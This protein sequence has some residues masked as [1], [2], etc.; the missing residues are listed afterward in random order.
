MVL[1]GHTLF[2]AI[3]VQTWTENDWTDCITAV[4]LGITILVVAIP[5]GLPLA[6]TL[7]MAYSILQMKKENI[8][9]RHL[10]GC[11]IMGSATSICSDKTGTLT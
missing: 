6:L 9:V 11:E 4:I 10:K 3:V 2:D 8:F 7:S 1:L 5:E